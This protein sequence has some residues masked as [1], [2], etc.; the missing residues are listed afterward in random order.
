[1]LRRTITPQSTETGLVKDVQSHLGHSRV[2]TTANEYM[3]E[4][5][6]SVQQT[7]GTVYAMLTSAATEQQQGRVGLSRYNRPSRCQPVKFGIKWHQVS[8]CSVAKLL[9]SWWAQ[10]DSN[11]RLPP[12]ESRSVNGIIELQENLGN[13]KAR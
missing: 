8:L 1:V 10:Q 3:Q 12:C 5:P 9:I 2:D 13:K 4:L 11:L 6:E 7:V